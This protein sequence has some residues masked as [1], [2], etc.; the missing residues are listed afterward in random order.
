MAYPPFSLL[1]LL[2]PTRPLMLTLMNVTKTSVYLTWEAPSSP[3]G[4][5][6]YYQIEYYASNTRLNNNIY[7]VGTKSLF[8][9]ITGLLPWTDYSVKIAAF[10]VVLGEYTNVETIRTLESGKYIS[11]IIISI[12]VQ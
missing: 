10:T 8:F 9:N 6:R 5:I 12:S 1:L 7:A 3:N 11:V 2:A 4:I